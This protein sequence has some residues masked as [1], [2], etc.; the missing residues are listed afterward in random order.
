MQGAMYQ[1]AAHNNA[2]L[3]RRATLARQADV[4]TVLY[5]QKDMGACLLSFGTVHVGSC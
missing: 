4:A 2:L 1:E 3:R 5:V